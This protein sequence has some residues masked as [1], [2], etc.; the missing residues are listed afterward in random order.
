MGGSESINYVEPVTNVKP[1]GESHT[2]RNPKYKDQVLDRPEPHLGTMK[3]I[4]IN[5]YKK[6]GQQGCLGI[7]NY[8]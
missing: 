7:T 1:E 3:D 2:Y 5:S 4:F 8:I 6:F